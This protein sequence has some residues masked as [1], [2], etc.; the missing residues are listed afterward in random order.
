MDV[1]QQ[2]QKIR[3]IADGS[4]TPIN[5]VPY[6]L[7]YVNGRPVARY[8]P[9]EQ[10][11]HINFEKMKQFLIIQSQKQG[12]KSNTTPKAAATPQ[13]FIPKYSIGK[14]I[15]NNKNVCYLGY[16]SAYKKK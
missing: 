3:S 8:V 13:S 2:Q 1:D 4:S 9:E 6:L 10:A 11:S 7:F 5:F 15:C 14:P 12:N 16:D